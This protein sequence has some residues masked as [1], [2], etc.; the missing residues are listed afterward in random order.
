M[1]KEKTVEEQLAE[2]NVLA[3]RLQG[4]LDTAAAD[5]TRLQGELEKAGRDLD[6]ATARE[7]DLKNQVTSANDAKA[8]VERKLEEAER[9]LAE[10][11]SAQVKQPK[12][13]K[14]VMLNVVSNTNYS[15]DIGDG[16]RVTPDVPVK[17]LRS[18]GNLLD[19]NMNAGL[20]VEYEG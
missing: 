18:P 7:A 1:A 4:D 2:A 17:A 9:S 11:A 10:A 3:A 13:A 6:D 16:I 15:Y 20:I 5:V 19:C 14:P 12:V 8:A